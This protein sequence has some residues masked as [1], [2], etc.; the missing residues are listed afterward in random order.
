VKRIETEYNIMLLKETGM[1]AVNVTAII[2]TGASP[3][4]IAET[5]YTTVEAADSFVK[6][7]KE[8]NGSERKT[9]FNRIKN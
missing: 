7:Y 1:S 2:A 5:L 4:I 9:L 3:Q 8:I 6:K